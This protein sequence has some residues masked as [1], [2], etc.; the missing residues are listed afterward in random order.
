[1]KNSLTQRAHAAYQSKRF[2]EALSLYRELKALMASSAYDFNIRR[3]EQ[4]LGQVSEYSSSITTELTSARRGDAIWDAKLAEGSKLV[5]LVRVIGNDLPGLHSNGQSLANLK[6]ILENEPEFPGVDKVYLLNRIVSDAKREEIKRVLKEHGK[7]FFEQVFK[8]EEYAKIPFYEDDLPT[9][10][11]WHDKKL[12]KWE[13]ICW[14]VSRRKLKNAY[15][16]NNNGARNYALDYGINRRYEWV[17]PLDGNCFISTEQFAQ[18]KQAIINADSRV[19]YL[20][21]PMERCIQNEPELAF[22]AATN[23]VEEPQIL[24]RRTARL[25][26]DEKRV[27]GNQP[28]VDLLKRLGVPGVWDAWDNEYPWKK[29]QVSIDKTET[30]SWAFSSSVFRLASGNVQATVSAKNR[31]HARAEAVIQ[32]CDKVYEYSCR[33]LNNK[34]NVDYLYYSACLEYQSDSDGTINKINDLFDKVYLVSLPHEREK[35]YKVS[36]QL[37]R[38]GLTFQH[39]E[40]VNGY[41][42]EPAE[43]YQ[44]YLKKPVGELSAFSEFRDY[45]LSRN[46]KLIESPGAVGYIHTYISILKDAKEQGY[47]SILILEDDIVFCDAFEARLA[48]FMHNVT[49][50]WK[51]LLLGASQYGWGSVN[52]SES[53]SRKHYYPRLHDT[54]GSF[55][56]AFKSD[57]YDE[58]IENQHHMEA[59]FDNLP[60]GVLYEKYLGECFV[61]FPYL[62]MPDVSTSSIREGREQH[63]HAN[64]V[65]WWVGDFK[66]PVHK[67]NVGVLVVS[68]NSVKH[69]SSFWRDDLPFNLRVLMLDAN[70]IVPVHKLEQIENI[71]TAN[72]HKEVI[73]TCELGYYDLLYKVP[74]EVELTKDLLIEEVEAALLGEMV[75]VPQLTRLEV[76]S[77]A[78]VV[79]RV[80]VI[81]PTY[82]RP[83]HLKRAAESVLTQDYPDLELLIVDDNGDGSEFDLD[84]RSVVDELTDRYPNRLIR[85]L[86]HKVNANGASARNTGIFASTGEYISFLDDD[87]VY[88]QGRISKSVEVLR[89]TNEDIGGVYCGFLGWNSPEYDPN[90]FLAGDLTKEILALDYKKHYLHTNTA[91]YKRAAIF[92]VHGFDPTYRRHQD[93]EINLR[94]FEK[95][96]IGVVK[97][98]LVRLAP[99]K[100]A[101]DN[102]LYGMDMLALKT[103]FLEDFASIISKFDVSDQANIYLKH[104]SEV[105]KYSQ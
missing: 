64:R 31:S 44:R 77:E 40:A 68:N 100:S 81:L 23:A 2:K 6:F 12:S 61:A 39:V 37:K 60:L 63:T 48:S 104:W 21:V 85:Y 95:Y 20:I 58:V 65:K 49:P 11:K 41:K 47:K 24:F 67:L 1:M 87:D 42:G 43:W 53:L 33:T 96:E 62:V 29:M 38:I 55:A 86:K 103:K 80:T 94:F 89:H 10:Q 105:A 17:F 57:V 50:D 22:K 73:S 26:F 91:T 34:S 45:E 84:V 52:F 51:I 46:M 74:K 83:A 102:K 72:G 76:G 36:N 90:R 71:Q 92:D 30:N 5:C 4:E 9:D 93:L 15:L 16:M 75:S 98:C 56:I 25:R 13:Q 3:C 18:L 54:K 82:K 101:V 27:Y 97:E 14:D 66:Y 35:R 69:L 19:S 79:G 7:P 70:G 32:F 78:V 99:T 59:P 28:K 88:M 8:K